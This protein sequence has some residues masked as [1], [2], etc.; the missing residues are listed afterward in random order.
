MLS[1]PCHTFLGPL[2]PLTL[3]YI[4]II[5]IKET[6]G[7]ERYQV[8]ETK[9]TKEANLGLGPLD[10]NWITENIAETCQITTCTQRRPSTV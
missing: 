5:Y 9:E 7:W 4:I 6:K 2:G 10:F 8:K 1:V 3:N